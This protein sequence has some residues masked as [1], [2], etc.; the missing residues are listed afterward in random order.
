MAEDSNHELTFIED[1][2]YF[3]H[4]FS[5]AI[6]IE[7]I[8]QGMQLLR[9]HPGYHPNIPVLWDLTGTKVDNI[10]SPDMLKFGRQVADRVVE[11]KRATRISMLVKSD[12]QFAVARQFVNLA[13]WADQQI[14]VTRSDSEAVRWVTR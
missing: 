11:A 5:G 2:E 10:F 14:L 3:V 6:T 8:M 13:G 9:E 1:E 4:R 7:L 12:I